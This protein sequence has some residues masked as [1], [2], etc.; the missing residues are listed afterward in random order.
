MRDMRS[1]RV[2]DCAGVWE[3]EAVGRDDVVWRWRGVNGAV[4]DI[5]LC[6]TVG[7][8]GIL[9]DCNAAWQVVSC[10]EALSRPSSRIGETSLESI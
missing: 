3:E 2:D 6:P 5:G 1:G 10:F 7:G 9:S 4:V 8:H